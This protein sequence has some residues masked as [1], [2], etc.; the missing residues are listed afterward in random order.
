MN[1][2]AKN[3]IL[4]VVIA[5]IL[6]TVFNNFGQ[7]RPSNPPMPYSQF[8]SDVRA[9]DVKS[10]Q[11]EGHQIVGFKTDGTNFSTYS[12]NDPGLM[13]DL[14]NNHVDVLAKPPESQGLLTQIFISWFPFLLLIG[15]WIFFMRQ[16]QGGGAGGR[17]AM[18]FGKSKARLL[19]DSAVRVCVGLPLPS[20]PMLVQPPPVST[21]SA[22]QFATE[23][24]LGVPPV[25]AGA[26]S[27]F[28]VTEPYQLFEL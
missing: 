7:R 15:V 6:M 3:I 27:G 4:W 18:S 16:M 9:G 26:T 10:I 11:I 24:T 5:V 23:L 14:I 2:I 13:G 19:G 25:T 17:G 22:S 8:I 21:Q 20:V 12:P 28:A 1:D